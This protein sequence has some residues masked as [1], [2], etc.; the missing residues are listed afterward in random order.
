MS[1]VGTYSSGRVPSA[2]WMVEFLTMTLAVASAMIAVRTTPSFL[3]VAPS[4][5]RVV[6]SP[7]PVTEA[8]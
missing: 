6:P 2:Q 5:T 1:P 7:V 8:P 4:T 3:M